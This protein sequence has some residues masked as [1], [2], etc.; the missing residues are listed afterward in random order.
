MSRKAGQLCRSE[1]HSGDGLGWGRRRWVLCKA[2][3]EALGHSGVLCPT[4]PFRLT[5]PLGDIGGGGFEQAF[6]SSDLHSKPAACLQV[7]P[8]DVLGIWT[9]GLDPI[10]ALGAEAIQNNAVVV[11]PTRGL[12]PAHVKLRGAAWV[13]KAQVCWCGRNCEE[14]Q[15]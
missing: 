11:P 8:G 6:H 1:G 10:P 2:Q 13:G 12:V 5:C 3:M 14:R 15:T 7:S 9:Q 4:Q